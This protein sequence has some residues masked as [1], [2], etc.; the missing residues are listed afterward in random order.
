MG[1]GGLAGDR[2]S[3]LVHGLLGACVLVRKTRGWGHGWGWSGRGPVHRAAPWGNVSGPCRG[4][5]KRGVQGNVRAR[6]GRACTCLNSTRAEGVPALLAHTR[7]PVTATAC[8]FCTAVDVHL[9]YCTPPVVLDEGVPDFWLNALANH[10]KVGPFITERDSEVLKYLEVRKEGGIRYTYR[11]VGCVHA[12][13]GRCG[14]DGWALEVYLS[15]AGVKYLEV[16]EGGQGPPPT[17]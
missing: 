3:G 5:M 10:N 17:G 15:G 13:R 1:G 6:R 8:S 9:L 16:R 4:R 2:L 12:G 11:D 14:T 7:W